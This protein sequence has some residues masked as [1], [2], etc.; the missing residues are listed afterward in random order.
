M[1]TITIYPDT[2]IRL[3]ARKLQLHL[4]IGRVDHV[5]HCGSDLMQRVP[6]VVYV[7]RRPRDGGE[8]VKHCLCISVVA[9]Y[10]M[11]G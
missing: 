11:V 5:F 8:Q 3:M 6:G 4:S 7:G 2:M 9:C 1:H 10:V